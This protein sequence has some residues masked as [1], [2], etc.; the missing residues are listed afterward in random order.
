MKKSMKILS[1]LLSLLLAVTSMPWSMEVQ[2]EQLDGNTVY[3]SGDYSYELDKA[4]TGVRI[5]EYEGEDEE[6][7]IPSEFKG[8]PVTE[9]GEEAFYNC[10]ALKKVIIPDSVT[11]IGD[12]AFSE[13]RALTEINMPESVR[14]IGSAAFSGTLWLENKR[15]ENSLVSVNNILIEV[16]TCSGDMTIPD[17]IVGIGGGVF[18]D[19][20][21]LTNITISDSVTNIGDSAFEGC[22]GLTEI[23]IPDGVTSIGASAFEECTGLTGIIIP[24]GVTS[25][26]DRVFSGCSGLTSIIISNNVTSVGD[27]A[28]SYCSGLTNITIPNSVT[29]IGDYAFRGC[30]GLTDIII[31][32]GVTSIG[33]WAFSGCYGLTE[34]TIPDSVTNIGYMVFE[35]CSNITD[36]IV[37]EGN[38]KYDSRENCNAIIETDSNTLIFGN[39]N[40]FIPNGVASIG[41]CAFQGCS[42]I[43]NIV[44]PD[45]VT[46]IGYNAFAYCGLTGITI[47]N[48]VT[49]IDEGAFYHCKL[50][51][52]TIPK[53]VTSIGNRVF[54][55]SIGLMG[56]T[57]E[58][59]NTKYDSRENCNAIIETDSNTLVFGC[60]NTFIPNSVT[61]IG[62][63]AFAE[64]GFLRDITIPNGVTHIGDYVFDWSGLK[65]I[66]I[67]NSVTSIGEEAFGYR[68]SSKIPDFVVYGY[69]GT[70]A[71]TY[72]KE[73][74][75]IFQIAGESGGTEV[76]PENISKATVTL[77]K[78]SYIYDGKAKCPSVTVKFNEKVL[79]LNKDYSVAYSNNVNPGTAKATITGKGGYT[80]NVEKTF[81]IMPEEKNGITCAKKTY[82]VVYGAKSFKI[83]AS[84]KSKLTYVSSDSKVAAVDKNTGKVTIKGCGIA[85][86]TVST[87]TESV[88]VTIKVSP[89]KQTVKSVKAAKGRKLTVKWKRDKTAA[90]YQVQLSLKNNFKKIEK[91][92]KLAKNAKTE[93]KFTRLKAGKKYYVRVRSYKKSKNQTL[94][95][96]WSKIKTVKIKK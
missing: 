73:N 48:S 83:N 10:V 20:G 38:L 29:S 43:T 69:S 93:Y 67:P 94:Y 53:S 11:S 79:T 9:I 58:E 89:K 64:C 82:N 66:T 33:D 52:I 61:S 81:T 15:K 56:V 18:K 14:N 71:E 57:V 25:I 54:N 13:C 23:I 6:I 91:N 16:Q 63:Y 72:A 74:G 41:D 92:K 21:S 31:S 17:G 22:T 85:T 26:G 95:G 19:C 35:G 86:I 59:G 60:N 27:S 36:I 62:D 90:G 24:D 45:T 3:V 34:I 7:V 28:F 40:S 96:A 30:S 4:G 65:S 76:L 5:R 55:V 75:M 50:T 84:S 32:N 42:R 80:G 68:G 47:P 46:H 12:Y 78:E 87:G 2:A 37:E 44:I 70:M 77:E 51:N 39:E 1:F 49:S 8:E 88:K